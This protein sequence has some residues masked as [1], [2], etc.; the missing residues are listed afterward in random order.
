MGSKFEESVY[1]VLSCEPVTPN[2]VV[3]KRLIL[4]DG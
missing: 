2:D 1:Q 4:N 3:K